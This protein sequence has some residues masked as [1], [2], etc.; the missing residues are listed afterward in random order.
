MEVGHSKEVGL[1]INAEKTKY[2]LLSR[3]WN[4]GQ[5]QDIKIAHRPFDN[6]LQFKYMGTR[7]TNHNLF[8]EE[9]KRRLNSG[10]A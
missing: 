10:N 9:I 5:N 8:R 7:V 1:E 3:H 6:V 4:A 2:M